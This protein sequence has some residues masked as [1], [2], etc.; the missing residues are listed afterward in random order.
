M[1]FAVFKFAT[2]LVS[3]SVTIVVARTLSPADYG[4]MSLASILTGYIEVFS[5]LGLGAAIVQRESISQQEYSSNFWFSLLVGLAFAFVA[6]WL[7]YPTAWIFDEPRVLPLTQFISVFFV[8][9]SL[10]TIPFNILMREL[11]FKV[12]GMIQLCSVAVS[13][14][15]MLWMAFAGF[16]P[17]TLIGGTFVLRTMSAVLLLAAAKWRP[18][19]HFRWDEVRRFLKFGLNVAGARSLFFVFQKSDVFVVGKVL[20]TEAVGFYA[21]AMQLA[22]MPTDKIAAIINQVS[23]PV[24]SRFQ[25]DLP[26]I[27]NIYL[28]TSKYLSILVSPLFLAGA[29][30]GDEIIRAVLGDTWAPVIF[31]FRVFCIAHLIVAITSINSPVHTSMGRSHWVLYFYL[32]AVAVM[33]GSLYIAAHYGLAAVAVPWLTV[34]PALTIAW[35]LVTLRKLRISP[36][37][38]LRSAGVHV[39][40]SMVIVASV[41]LLMAA[42]G[43]VPLV[44]VDYRL[45]LS[46]ELAVAATAYL[47]Y[48]WIRERQT[49]VDL[50]Q[51]R[52]V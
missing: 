29:I 49:V 11:R 44:S 12:I 40:A 50:W 38:Y 36:T 51:L 33:P 26:G 17:W 41:K 15:A 18:D 1:W 23:F 46:Q 20:G 34:F 25:N 47:T 42:V 3:W 39:L 37:S 10:T 32:A 24:F 52:K 4:L 30:W 48:L 45:L 2:Q 8:I 27:Q 43:S 16:G 28:K 13:S 21:L 35:T 14:L 6:F 19:F 7:A 22:S 31:L 9:G 5:E